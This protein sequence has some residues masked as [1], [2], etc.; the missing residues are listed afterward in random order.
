[1]G[2]EV[3]P[4][5]SA[6]PVSYLEREG[7]KEKAEERG[8]N[9]E[10]ESQQGSSTERSISRTPTQI[11]GDLHSV[12]GQTRLAPRAGA[13]RGRARSPITSPKRR[14]PR[15]VYRLLLE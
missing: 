4:A 7:Q 6:V 5:A 1:M 9:P 3:V 8:E 10:R 13:W 11:T 15:A 14:V 12:Q 2:F